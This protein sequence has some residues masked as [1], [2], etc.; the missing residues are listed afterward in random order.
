MNWTYYD[1]ATGLFLPGSQLHSTLA[2]LANNTPEGHGAMEGVFDR[3]KHR[4]DL[5]T[6]EVIEYVTP[7]PG[8]TAEQMRQ[9]R[10]RRLAECDWVIIR[11]NELEA[12][13]P[14]AWKAYRK[15][16]RDVPDQPGFPGAV[17]WPV[18]PV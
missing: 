15:A 5:E 3:F 7:R 8:P 17:E 2:A 9:E 12:P 16:L 14:A 6:G 18:A 1:L 4:V 13:V 10:D 11:A